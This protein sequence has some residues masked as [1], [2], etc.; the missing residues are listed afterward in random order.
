MEGLYGFY[1]DRLKSSIGYTSKRRVAAFADLQQMIQVIELSSA[2]SVRAPVELKSSL[3]SG[4]GNAGRH[5]L[6]GQVIF[7]IT[8]TF[9]LTRTGSSMPFI[10]LPAEKPT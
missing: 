4:I 10:E 1:F 3:S 2:S 7:V 5:C 6:D 9:G 8:Q